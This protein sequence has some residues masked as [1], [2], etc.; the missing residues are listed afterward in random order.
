MKRSSAAAGAV[1]LVIG[2]LSSLAFAKVRVSEQGFFVDGEYFFP[3]GVNYMPRDSAIWMWEEFDPHA[4][5]RE[6][7]IL[8]DMHLNTVRTFVFWEDLNPAPGVIS[9]HNLEQIEKLMDIA[10]EEGVMIVLA[11][12]TGHMSGGNWYPDWII[13]GESDGEGIYRRILFRPPTLQPLREVRD[14]YEDEMALDNQILMAQAL[15]RKLKDHPALLYWDLGNEPQ[16]WLVPRTPQAGQEYVRAQVE[17][18]KAIDPHHP[19]ALGMGKFAEQS[20]FHSYGEKGLAKVE[21]LYPVHTYPSGYYPLT[22]QVVDKYVTYYAGFENRLS[23]AAGIPVQFQEFGM[24]DWYFAAVPPAEREEKLAGYYR[25]SMWCSQLAGA[26]SGVLAWMSNDYRKSLFF[27]R[28]YLSRPYELDFGVIDQDYNKKVSGEE[29]MKF[30]EIIDRVYDKPPLREFNKVAIVI[31][32]GYQSAGNGKDRKDGVFQPTR[33]NY[34]RFFFSAWLVMRQ[35]GVAPIFVPFGEDAGDVKLAMVPGLSRWQDKETAYIEDLMSK[36]AMVYVAGPHTPY[37]GEQVNGPVYTAS[38]EVHQQKDRFVYEA[39]S[40]ELENAFEPDEERLGKMRDFYSSLL[41]KAD[42]QPE[43]KISEAFVEGGIL[44]GEWLVLINHLE[45]T[46]RTDITFRRKT[47]IKE[48]FYGSGLQGGPALSLPVS[49][50]PYGTEVCR[51]E[52]CD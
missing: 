5:R 1:L 51:I 32:Q 2:F 31:P 8:K 14:I 15:A 41:S 38:M 44:N 50:A 9:E 12:N 19:V 40:T 3:V 33:K 52:L 48:C 25:C 24:S 10:R 35:L 29:L 16:Y 4:I 34:N 27:K 26:Y 20:G 21:D 37:P 49:L 46:V 13:K 43:L 47:K 7:R 28:P 36:G 17:A 23:R 39:Q 22:A 6:F 42:I 18:I 30:A 45:R 11:L